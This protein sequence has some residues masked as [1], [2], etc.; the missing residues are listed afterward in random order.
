M[1]ALRIQIAVGR[2][3]SGDIEASSRVV[4]YLRFT[5]VN[6][7]FERPTIVSPDQAARPNNASS[8]LWW[9]GCRR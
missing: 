8:C 4:R 2:E 1:A 5:A 7:G 3:D 9:R 6:R